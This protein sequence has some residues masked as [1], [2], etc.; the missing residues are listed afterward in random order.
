MLLNLTL[1]SYDP[2]FAWAVVQTVGAVV[3]LAALLCS[4]ILTVK[5]FRRQ[6]RA[7]LQIAVSLL[8][9]VSLAVNVNYAVGCWR[10]VSLPLTVPDDFV[11]TDHP[12]QYVAYDRF[13]LD[14]VE[15]TKLGGLFGNRGLL[16]DRS[17]PAGH[18]IPSSK[19]TSRWLWET[20]YRVADD[21]GFGMLRDGTLLYVPAERYDECMAY[22]SDPENLCWSVLRD[23]EEYPLSDGFCEAY[24]E[25]LVSHDSTE[26]QLIVRTDPERSNV[27]TYRIETYSIDGIVESLHLAYNSFAEYNGDIYAVTEYI[28]SSDGSLYL[29]LPV[30][31]ELAELVISELK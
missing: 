1:P 25:Y 5:E 22:Y 28:Y 13:I 2:E 8:I 18:Y 12:V 19:P 23:G 21:H 30:T 24:R 4:V 15:Y 11:M 31:D 16:D 20:Y 26:G 6:K 7:V 10:S 17:S 27:E 14:G 9:A 3:L 29:L